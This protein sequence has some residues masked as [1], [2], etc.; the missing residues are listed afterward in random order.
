MPAALSSSQQT[1]TIQAR[2][3]DVLPS[4]DIGPSARSPRPDSSLFI[5]IYL[6]VTM[7]SACVCVYKRERQNEL[8]LIFQISE[9]AA[10]AAKGPRRIK[11]EKRIGPPLFC[12]ANR[13]QRPDTHTHTHRRKSLSFR[14]QHFFNSSPNETRAPSCIVRN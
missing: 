1:Y 9:C 6:H 11:C 3:D 2:G 14:E 5:R 13:Q 12:R 7:R 8:G 4:G 10:R